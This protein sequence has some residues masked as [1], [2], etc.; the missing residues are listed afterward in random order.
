VYEVGQRVRIRERTWMVLEDRADSMSGDHVLRVRS[1]DAQ[2]GGREYTFVYRP[3]TSHG[4]ETGTLLE[5]ITPLPTAELRWS[6][7][8]PPSQWERL[9][10]AYRLSI[11]HSAGH[12]L[13]LSRARLMIEP[14]QL[15]PVLQVLSAPRQRFL[16]AEDVGMGKTIEAGLIAMELIARERGDRILIVVPAALQDQWADEM[17]D[18]FGLEFAILDSD[19]LAK[20][21]I[22]RL[23]SGA[24]PWEYASR[25]ITSVDFAKQERILRALKKTH[26]DLTIV[27]E[28]HYLAESGTDAAPV[29]T[30]RS[31]LYYLTGTHELIR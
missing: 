21:L 16:L 25:V 19:Y 22:P 23:P 14:Y 31:V 2:S 6:P 15:A 18:K 17:R 24:N 28:A 1:T 27:D 7:G 20:D 29:R 11:A 26:W 10:T 12:L 9:Q 3:T 30:D 5:Q 13:G 8:T 4:D